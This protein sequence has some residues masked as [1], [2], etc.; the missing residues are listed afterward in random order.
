MKLS[1]ISMVTST[2]LALHIHAV[3]VVTPVP[4]STYVRFHIETLPESGTLS[5]SASFQLHHTPWGTRASFGERGISSKPHTFTE[6][7][8]TPWY[9][10]QDAEN[11][12]RFGKAQV[13]MRLNVSD[14]A[15][16]ATEFAIGKPRPITAKPRELKPVQLEEEVGDLLAELEG[17]TDVKKEA[18]VPEPFALKVIRR[19]P[20]NV[21]DG[22]AYSFST[23]L[24][25]VQTLRDHARR[26]YQKALAATGEK[27]FPM[28]RPPMLTTPAWARATGPAGDYMCKTLRLL[29]FNAVE[30]RDP[31]KKAKLYGWTTTSAQ[32]WPPA[33]LPHDPKAT[34]QRYDDHYKARPPKFSVADNVQAT[35]Y[36]VA[37]EPGEIQR[38]E[39]GS[40]TFRFREN[41]EG[42]P[43]FVDETGGG[44]LRTRKS[45]YQGYL[46][47]ATISATER[48]VTF[49]AGLSEKNPTQGVF[50]TVGKLRQDAPQNVL[51][52]HVEG[53]QSS[54]VRTGANLSSQ[55]R[56]FRLVHDESE[57]ALFLD[58]KQI[59]LLKD[60]PKSGGFSIRGPRKSIL[61]LTL[62]PLQPD[63]RLRPV[64]SF[65]NKPKDDLLA[66]LEEDLLAPEKEVKV[67]T[68][69][70]ADLRTEIETNW[71]LEG[72]SEEARNGFR[73]WLKEQGVKPDLFGKDS[74][75]D[76]SP[77]TLAHI[78]ETPEEKRLYYWSR[79][80]SA[81]R[82]PKMFAQACEA[83]G[84]VSPNPDLRRFV[85]LSGHA[86]Y[87]PSEMPLDMFDLASYPDVT[88]GVSDWMSTGG[89][90]WD[91]HQAVAYS[92]APYNSGARRYGD[93]PINFP[94]MHCVWPD[95]LRAYTQFGN[96]C[97]TISF[98]NYGPYYAA[99][100]GMWSE[101]AG[102]HKTAHLLNN[103]L[104]QVDD[105]AGKG[106]LR[107]SRV[108][109][110]Y[111]RSTEYWNPKSTFSDK[112]A[113][114]LALSHE[115]YQPE[116]ITEEQI[117][118]GALQHYDALYVLETHVSQAATQ[119]ILN[120]TNS[121]GLLWTCADAFLKDEYDTP[122]DVLASTFALKR[123][124]APT[125]ETP[126]TQSI[127]PNSDNGD[128]PSHNLNI[129]Q[130]L[131][132]LDHPNAE[133]LASYKDG[134]AAW[135]EFTHGK[136]HVVYLGHRPG[137]AYTRKAI[138]LPG[139]RTIWPDFPRAPIT[140][141][142]HHQKVSRDLILSE[143]I[144][145]AHALH[146]KAGDLVVLANMRADDIQDLQ[147]QLRTPQRPHSVQ[148]F[149]PEGDLID[150]PFS[151]AEEHITLTLPKLPSF[152]SGWNEIGQ[153]LVVRYQPAPEDP[154][155]ANLRQQTLAELESEDPETLATAAW[156]VGFF[157]Q[158]NLAEKLP[159]L[160][161]HPDWK[162]RRSA[163]ESLGRLQHSPSA[164][165]LQN[166][167]LTEPD[168][169]VQADLLHAL[170]QLKDPRFQEHH[171]RFTNTNDPFLLREAQ[172]AQQTYDPQPSPK[173]LHQDPFRQKLATANPSQLKELFQ[174]RQNL[175]P[176]QKL[177]LLAY[178][179]SQFP[180]RFGND[181]SAWEGYLQK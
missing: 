25:Q 54:L 34:Q 9:R 29:G 1:L 19:I 97:K 178:L 177:L 39:L 119:K 130:P 171:Q 64:L 66:E 159:Q 121:G 61:S 7:G 72:G 40:P 140:Q 91:S 106:I 51:T 136:G 113:T 167:L 67:E 117:A 135:V 65:E 17:K 145:L 57:A 95:V 137:F 68:T 143:P 63:E 116:L 132:S 164:D 166:T 134:P 158:W 33:F 93:Q 15:Q 30:T 31:I 123:V 179:P 80:Y 148:L 78:A 149:N 176:R 70:V 142:L 75:Q 60:A 133:V 53:R 172:L 107:P 173:A 73:N 24:S 96:N 45:D 114:F 38:E 35:I 150:H 43:S 99:T 118:D 120:W 82:T 103:R 98:Y 50:W 28:M 22:K 69:K 85:A 12:S 111:S 42:Q 44:I 157:P 13:S 147:V 168:L 104:A 155:I 139:M 8:T 79:R 83:I 125:T 180:E 86:L 152:L 110:L 128:F 156:R 36:Q 46:L 4:D 76:L 84:K 141:A 94:M 23:N 160:L 165:L 48:K 6:I 100:E 81:W 37:D 88:P 47:K 126:V 108:A 162:V 56:K 115:Y 122:V 127:V 5:L 112:R 92:V 174:N 77:L 124:F 153:I 144:V 131:A 154:R 102:S 87:F 52:G 32:Y 41:K 129:Q 151:Y 26:N 138:R 90:R 3:D 16:G 49:H 27:M 89:W 161:Q 101:S 14:E 74:Y 163:A 175:T 59:A 10:L 169:H 20:W 181:E 11:F 71:R 55:P 21:P 62:R 58:G 105:L 146:S 170:A 2:F 109:L 18:P